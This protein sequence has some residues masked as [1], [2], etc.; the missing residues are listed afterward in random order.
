MLR[1][2]SYLQNQETGRFEGSSPGDGSGATGKPAGK[3]LDKV[4]K[5]ADAAR[6]VIRKGIDSARATAE[7]VVEAGKKTLAL[8]GK[9][10]REAGNAAEGARIFYE[11]NKAKTAEAN[12]A[13][14]KMNQDKTYHYEANCESTRLG[15][16]G[17]KAAELL[18]WAKE[19][20]DV[21]TG[22]NTEEESADDMKANVAGR[23]ADPNKTCKEAAQNYWDNLPKENNSGKV[24]S[25]KKID[26]F[27]TRKKG[28]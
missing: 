12:K 2:R 26:L 16:G 6:D 17:R 8:P 23:S 3:V 24:I 4:D 25:E 19:K 20:Y 14:L 21:K 13:P 1:K 5:A 15:P 27:G 28:R 22:G 10:A 9:A 18:S 7:V 11:K